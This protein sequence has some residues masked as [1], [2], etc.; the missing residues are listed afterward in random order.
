MAAARRATNGVK[1]TFDNPKRYSLVG[2]TAG[3]EF[4]DLVQ[5]MLPC[6]LGDHGIAVFEV[7]P[8]E[9]QIHRGLF[10]SFVQRK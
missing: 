9:A 7:N 1:P 5:D 10:A 3:F 6:A 4:D 8:S 2:R